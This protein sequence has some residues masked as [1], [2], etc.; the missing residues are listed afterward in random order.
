[1][2]ARAVEGKDFT[3]RLPADGRSYTLLSGPKG[4]ALSP[5][6]VITWRP[7]KA[8]VGP[9]EIKV[10]VVS[11]GKP[12]IERHTLEVLDKDLVA[13]GGGD[14]SRA[15]NFTGVPL[16]QQNHK[17][18]WSADRAHM[19]LL[20]GRTLQI[21][22]PDARQVVATHTLERYC[23]NIAE[24]PDSYV[25]VGGMELRLFDKKTLKI[26]KT[27][28]L[29]K[30][31]CIHDFALHPKKKVT[32][33]SVENIAAK[34][35]DEP[36]EAL[37]IVRVNEESGDITELPRIYGRWIA[38]DPEG[39]YLIAAYKDVFKTGEHY[40]LNPD[41]NLITIPEYGN[42]D[43]LMRYRLDGD[44]PHLEEVLRKAGGNGQRLVL[45]P[46]GTHA[47]YLSF[48]GYPDFSRNIAAFDVTNLKKESVTYRTK[49]RADCKRLAYH[50]V[51]DLV[52]SPGSGSAVLYDRRS[53][54]EEPN[55]LKLTAKGLGK[56]QVDDLMF[57]ADGKHLI[58]AV[59]EVGRG[60][61]LRSV[62]LNLSPAERNRL[63]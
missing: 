58:F 22:S 7:G 59:T 46:D 41:W 52:A 2:L 1:M 62:P 16:S 45:S 38:V 61:Y 8:D 42:I 9:H 14:P 54:E 50:P 32:F 31:R 11:A 51:L 19:L 6:G 13:G 39:K 34:V 63:K 21:L 35:I 60:R 10:R 44:A 3:H 20:Q 24:R 18:L 25:A 28:S 30:Y 57:S 26:R 53:G 56:A 37:R 55:R 15:D 49:D 33:V 12:A 17:L 4:L 29:A 36:A 23:D 5:Q 43:M 48:V 47:A 40:H 27:V